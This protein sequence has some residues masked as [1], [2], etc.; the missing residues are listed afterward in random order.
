MSSFIWLF[1][2]EVKDTYFAGTTLNVSEDLLQ[3]QCFSGFCEITCF[4]LIEV[5][6]GTY[7]TV[8]TIISVPLYR[9]S[10]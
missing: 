6:P 2:G 3:E 5:D 1:S 4:D 9:V 7:R 8:N 10:S